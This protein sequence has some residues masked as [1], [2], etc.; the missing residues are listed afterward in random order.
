[1]ANFCTQCGAGLDSGARFCTRCGAA[2][3]DS[4]AAASTLS[5]APPAVASSPAATRAVPGSSSSSSALKIVLIVLGVFVGLGLLAGAA[6]I[7]GLWGLSRAVKVEPGGE[8]VSISTP[9]GTMT[10]GKAVMTEAELG[11]PIYPG[12]TAE[13]GSLRLG[14]AQGSMGAY[15]F[16]TPDAPE[17]VLEFYRSRLASRVDIVTTGQGGIITAAPSEKEGFM[18][19][20]ARDEDRGDT[21][22]SIVRGLAAQ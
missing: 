11:L 4:V 13:E 17:Q 1:M 14:T 8:K 10:A 21:I 9:M 15:A 3:A 7:F 5:P 12:A 20:V 22:I 19:S 2:V 18:I 6:V 16:R